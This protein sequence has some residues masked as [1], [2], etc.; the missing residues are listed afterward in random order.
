MPGYEGNI[1]KARNGRSEDSIV[2]VA[3]VVKF[4]TCHVHGI[5]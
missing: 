4:L 2:L 3:L 5:F 1:S